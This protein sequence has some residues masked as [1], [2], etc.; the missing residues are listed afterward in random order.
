[1]LCPN[2]P[3]EAAAFVN[4]IPHLH[5]IWVW[6]AHLWRRI[7][8]KE[9]SEAAASLTTTTEGGE[10]C[11]C[12]VSRHSEEPMTATAAGSKGDRETGA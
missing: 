2:D 5:A 11:T 4:L 3:Q 8:H 6:C 10:G 9:V 7:R 12:V 1:M